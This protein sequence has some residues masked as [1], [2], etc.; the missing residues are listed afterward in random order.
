MGE[1]VGL[2][3]ALFDENVPALGVPVAGPFLVCPAEGERKVG[4]ARAE[5]FLEWAFQKSPTVE[6][7][8]VVDESMDT[9]LT[10]KRGLLLAYLGHP[11]VVETELSGQ[12]GLVMAREERLCPDHIGPLGESR[13]PPLVVLRDRMELRKVEGQD[14]GTVRLVSTGGGRSVGLGL[15]SFGIGNIGAHR[16]SR[17]RDRLAERAH[18]G[19]VLRPLEVRG[20]G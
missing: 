7:V 20:A 18:R 6:P 13:L 8:V 11:Q 10:G 9:V 5:H 15:R 2:A 1:I 16:A 14:L 3:E 4:V 12:M 17:F 19:R